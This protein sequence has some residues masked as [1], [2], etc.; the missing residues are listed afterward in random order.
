SGSSTSTGSTATAAGSSS[1]S[2]MRPAAARRTAPAGICSTPSREPTW[3]RW[4][5][6]SSWTS[7]S[8]TTPP[9]PPTRAVSAPSHPPG[10]GSPCRFAAA[11]SIPG[12]LALVAALYRKYR[13]QTFAD[14][15]GQEAVVRTLT[16]AIEQDKVRQAYLF[17][18]PRGTGKTSLARILA[19]SVNCANGPRVTPDTTSHPSVAASNRPPLHVTAPDPA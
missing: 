14:V 2:P 10:T 7:T 19:K 12:K 3:A 11:S 6:G 18:G 8:P 4:T 1:R 13:P 9:A 16:N 15:V 5:A 17:A